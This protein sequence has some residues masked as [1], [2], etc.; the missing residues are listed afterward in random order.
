M[1]P[2]A[3]I[4]KWN[5]VTLKE[6]SASQSH[7]IDLCRLLDEPDPVSADPTGEWYCFE[8]GA[9]K[10]GGGDGWADVWSL[11]EAEH[12]RPETLP[13]HSRRHAPT[14]R[15]ARPVPLDWSP[16][17]A[18]AAG[19]TAGYWSGFCPFRPPFYV[20]E[21]PMSTISFD[22]HKFIRRLETAG[23]SQDQAEAVADAFKGAQNE[24]RPLTQ[25]YLDYRLKAELAELKAEM[26]NIKVDLIKWMTGALVAQ[27]AVIAALVKL[28]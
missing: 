24:Q 22:T 17:T 6:R 16:P 25:E 23:F 27:I 7:F 14:F 26:T 20:M 15:R 8:K 21:R 10:A 11:L 1:T 4:A 2:D 28:L 19:Q 5:G 3:F 12:Q 18:F 13:R 9:K